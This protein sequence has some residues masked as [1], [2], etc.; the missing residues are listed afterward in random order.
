MTNDQLA[1]ELLLDPTFQLD[2]SGGCSVENPVFHSIRESFHKAFWDSLFDDLLVPIPCYMRVLR[3][4]GEIRDGI[5]DLVGSREA[6]AITEV[7]DLDLI[8]QQTQ[9]GSYCWGSCCRLVGAVVAVIQ[10]VQS[11]KR[12]DETKERWA[13]CQ[14][15]L[16]SD[17]AATADAKPRAF[18]KAL[19][20][21]LDR[22][23]AVRIDAANGRLRL[24]AP[25]IKD[26]G[27][28]YE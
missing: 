7:I 4:L 14:K 15:E 22:V 18:C 16:Q 9:V 6:G 12:D 25:V 21:L 13:E 26:H 5:N 3:V 1:H 11:P 19:E 24:I 20:F 28:D 23:N 2:E 27:I 10:R 17:S 8:K